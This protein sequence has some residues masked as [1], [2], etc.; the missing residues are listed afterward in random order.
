MAFA[1]PGKHITRAYSHAF[2]VIAILLLS[3]STESAYCSHIK[4]KY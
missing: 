2:F 4:D 1:R 3:D